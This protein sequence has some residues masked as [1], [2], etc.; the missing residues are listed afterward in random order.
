MCVIINK[1]KTP[2]RALHCQKL[3]RN[4]RCMIKN[5]YQN[6][7]VSPFAARW[8]YQH[9]LPPRSVL[10]TLYVSEGKNRFSGL[11]PLIRNEFGQFWY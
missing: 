11:F 7:L 2:S 3:I 9:A 1:E 10:H 6:E 8:Y 5:K 4:F